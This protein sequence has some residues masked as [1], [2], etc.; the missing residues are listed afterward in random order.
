MK[1]RASNGEFNG[2]TLLGYD[3]VNKQLVVNE[4]ESEIVK[5]MFEMRAEGMGYKTIA[6]RLNSYGYKTK[7]GNNFGIC[8]VRLILHNKEYV[9]VNTWGKK[10]GT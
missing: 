1:K 7:R 10:D 4:Q 5:R 9:G 8:A 6:N 3:I 2:G